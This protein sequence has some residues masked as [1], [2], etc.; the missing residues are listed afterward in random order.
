M[1]DGTPNGTPNP[2][3][4]RRLSRRSS[5]REPGT[6]DEDPPTAALSCY[7]NLVS[8]PTPLSP[9]VVTLGNLDSRM[10]RVIGEVQVDAVPISGPPLQQPS[11][12]SSVQE[13][14][15]QTFPIAGPSSS[16]SQRS[17]Q[18]IV[19]EE[20]R[21]P[22]IEIPVPVVGALAVPGL[23][24]LELLNAPIV[25]ALE[26]PVVEMLAGPVDV[27]V[28]LHQELLLVEVPMDMSSAR[29]RRQLP[30]DLRQPQPLVLFPQ[31]KNLQL[32]NGRPDE[33]G[34]QESRRLLND[35]AE[36]LLNN[37]RMSDIR[38]V[39]GEGKVD[40]YG[41]KTILAMGSPVFE[42]QFFG[43]FKSTDEVIEL[44]DFEPDIFLLFLKYLYTDTLDE[45]IDDQKILNL[46]RPAK[47][48]I[49][50]HLIE[51]CS[52]ILMSELKPENIF[53]VHNYADFF[54]LPKL[55][56]ACL[57]FIDR[58]CEAIVQTEEFTL[59]SA[60]IL[61]SFLIRDGLNM[62]ELEI[63][64]A[65]LR[66][67]ELE[68][69][70]NNI[71]PTD[72]NLR[73]AIGE[74]LFLVRFPTM[75]PEEFATEVAPRNILTAEESRSIF[76]FMCA[77]YHNKMNPAFIP[78]FPIKKRGFYPQQYLVSRFSGE[79]VAHS[80]NYRSGEIYTYRFNIKSDRQIF[81]KGVNIFS[82]KCG[83][84]AQYGDQ[85]RFNGAVYLYECDAA[86]GDRDL[87]TGE[88][89]RKQF[90]R[91]GSLESE[92]ET[93]SG[94]RFFPV[95][96]DNEVRIPP[97]Q[98]ITVCAVVSVASSNYQQQPLNTF[99]GTDEQ[100]EVSVR[101]AENLEVNFTFSNCNGETSVGKYTQSQIPEIIF[102]L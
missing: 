24:A 18:W 64:K 22:E 76:I 65:V 39:V 12:S 25:E 13:R 73:G 77:G 44:P 27:P 8:V 93:T 87:A 5:R 1:M 99:M 34:W 101:C 90:T 47:K 67:A 19:E 37:K 100:T 75:T 38:F 29:E 51:K 80:L 55:G 61:T 7:N 82:I 62:T 43:M 14:R 3:K 57:R 54:D 50:P 89:A 85:R 84:N 16:S 21:A 83:V 69:E 32:T 46:L 86:V 102:S 78:R 23:N 95:L 31:Q 17:V 71:E 98:M 96:F 6:S 53:Q 66:W 58:E 74:N 10:E 30:Q 9:R 4:R 56:G 63:F 59:L 60:E 40:M 42:A 36:Y 33:Q 68:C 97:N 26:R 28:P 79:P 52:D 72:S 41:H 48:Y 2:I 91:D 88:K 49:V 45:P 11:S 81:L 92:F 35:R 20:Q 94:S 15:V 70:R